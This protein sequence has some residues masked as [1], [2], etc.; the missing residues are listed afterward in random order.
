ME[1]QTSL[2]QLIQGLMPEGAGVVEGTVTNASPLE[3]TL[4]NDDKMT[5]SA[6]SFIVPEH[7][8]DREI[9]ADIM[10][11]CGALYA[12]TGAEDEEGGHGHPGIEKSGRHGHELESF[13]LTGGKL[14]LHTGLKAGEIVYLLSYNKGKKYYVLDRRG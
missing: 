3:I 8:T 9:E 11:D 7:L 5:L 12:P 6:N 1:E 14:I 2:K 10:M 4:T 13:Q